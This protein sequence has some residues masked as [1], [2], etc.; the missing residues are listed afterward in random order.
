MIWWEVL[1][2]FIAPLWGC[3]AAIILRKHATANYKLVLSFSGAFLFT[4]VI[5]HLL[6]ETF[7][8]YPKAGLFI[9]AGFFIQILLEQLTHGI[10]HGHFHEHKENTSYILA[11]LVGLSVHSLMDGLPLSDRNLIE[12]THHSILYGISIHKIPEG[13]ALASI[14][15]FSG[16]SNVRIFVLG[17]LFSLVAPLAMFFGGFLNDYNPIWLHAL[18]AVAIGSF[19]HVSTTILFESEEKRHGLGWKKILAI[20]AGGGIALLFG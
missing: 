3:I 5:L 20:A 6:P 8:A 19:L 4:I 17:I 18:I 10:E 14:L 1:L 13:F 12:S 9:L 15:M 16:Y 2:L 7:S 11:L